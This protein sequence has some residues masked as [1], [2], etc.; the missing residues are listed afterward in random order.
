METAWVKQEPARSIPTCKH[1]WA[2]SLKGSLLAYTDRQISTGNYTGDK[3]Y[4]SHFTKSR[5]FILLRSDY[6][7]DIASLH[8]SLGLGFSVGG[9]SVMSPL[10]S[11]KEHEVMVVSDKMDADFIKVWTGIMRM[12]NIKLELWCRSLG[13]SWPMSGSRPF[14]LRVGSRGA[15]HSSVSDVSSLEMYS[16]YSVNTDPIN[17]IDTLKAVL[18]EME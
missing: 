2:G 5:N 16:V 3:F 4:L 1:G 8:R 13:M 18:E 7:R 6:W 17:T 15:C 10:T 12:Y 14:I 9:V 11:H